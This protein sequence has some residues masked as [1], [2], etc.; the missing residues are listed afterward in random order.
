MQNQ[1]PLTRQPQLRAGD[2][3]IRDGRL[4]QVTAG[5]ARLGLVDVTD[6]L[7]GVVELV[8][9]FKLSGLMVVTRWVRAGCPFVLIGK[10]RFFSLPA[11]INW[12]AEKGY[13]PQELR[14]GKGLMKA[15]KRSKKA[16]WRKGAMQPKGGEE[17][18][19]GR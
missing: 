7:I 5:G 1:Q 10:R 12:L 9:H 18:A 14:K 3:L 4:L 13:Q 11:V 15:R 8:G 2:I 19:G 17:K 16:G 6:V